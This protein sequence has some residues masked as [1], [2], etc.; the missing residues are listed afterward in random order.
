MSFHNWLQSLRSALTPGRGQ[1]QHGRRGLPRATTHRPNLEV[2]EGRCLLSFSPAVSYPVGANPQA[3]VAGDFNNDT[4]L[5]LAVAN[6]NS[7][8]NVSVLLGN[9]DGTFTASENYGTGA[10]A[11]SIEVGD[12]DGDGN[13]DLATANAAGVSVLPG[14]GDGTFGT[15]SN[16]DFT[17]LGSNPR[18]VAV[19]DFN[20]DGLLDLGVVSNTYYPSSGMYYY[21][22]HYEGRATVLLGNGAGGFL[23]PN[24]ASLGYGY[25]TSAAVADFNGDTIDELATVNRDLGRV[26]VLFGG[27]GG[28]T[29]STGYYNHPTSVAAGDVNGDNA[30]DLITANN[31]GTVS[32]LLGN[33]LGDF[34]ARQSYS[35]GVWGQSVA[36]GDF[37]QDNMLD[38]VTLGNPGGGNPAHVHVLLGHGDGTFAIPIDQSLNFGNLASG[39]AIGDFN[40]DGLPDVAAATTANFGG[41][42]NVLINA[43]GWYFPATLAIKD[44]TVSEGDSGTVAA[45]FTV[46]RGDNLNSTVTVNYSTANGGALAGSDYVAQSG[47]LTFGPGETTKPITILVNGD[48]IDEYDQAFYVNLYAATGANITD[49]RGV[50]TILDND[51]PPTITITTKVSAKEGHSSTK[52]FDFIV[53]LSAPSEKEVR[54]NF[55]TADGSATTADNDYVAKSGTLIFSPGQTSKTISVAVKGDTKKEANETFFVNLS[56]ATNGTILGAQGIGEILD[57]DTLSNGGKP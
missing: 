15:A 7:N 47:T 9:P 3:V 12:F 49:S 32:V 34:G 41:N 40:G 52:K 55:A 21:D 5:D 4:V 22:Q 18:S 29:F 50:G 14:N 17:G 39:L 16:F 8:S 30:A 28:P 35:S 25:F 1:R 46:T 33:G 56:G 38:I 23:E 6:Y 2:L 11:L 31:D 19:G 36:V 57:D 10:G 43:G 48:L 51:P 13:L 45:V 44:V 37:N 54:V 42:V 20:G 53:T 24:T 27:L 26:S